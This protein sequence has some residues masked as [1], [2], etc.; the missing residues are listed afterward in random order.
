M[1]SLLSN[2]VTF[3]NQ[4]KPNTQDTLDQ[5]KELIKQRD[6][7][8]S[9]INI[10]KSML[11]NQEHEFKSLDIEIAERLQSIDLEDAK[12][13]MPNERTVSLKL[14]TF[15]SS[16]KDTID[17][18]VLKQHFIKQGNEDLIR[19]EFTVSLTHSHIRK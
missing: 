8:N 5:I 6:S 12:I 19:E 11:S 18:K 9:E 7:L 2:V 16:S 3:M 4:P 13:R 10:T 14:E 1:K 15:C 17:E